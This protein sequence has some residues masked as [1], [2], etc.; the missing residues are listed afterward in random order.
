[1]RVAAAAVVAVV[2][3][4][5][6]ETA[7]AQTD[8]SR[9]MLSVNAA[10]EPGDEE[11]TDTGTFTLY[12]EA[13]VL[14]VSG[15]SSTGAIFD[16]GAAV[17]VTGQFTLGLSYH[18]GASADEQTA[19]G[20]A[21]HPVVFNRPRPFSVTVPEAKRIEQ[22]VHISAGYLVPLGEKFDL[23]IYGGPTQFRYSQQVIGSVTITE[24]S[25]AF[26]AVNATPT[27]V[28]RKENIWGGHIGADMSYPIATSGVTSFRLGGYIR[29]A[30]A[31]SEF[32]VVS[33][34]VETETGGVQYG[35]GL[36]VRF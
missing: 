11:F 36:R 22:A 14:T 17:R 28:A 15:R 21:P 7:F 20:L 12:D 30:Q 9:F 18:R 27:V 16:F 29:Y 24:A 33:N 35:A 26:T 1:M 3:F 32:L 2:V 19:S 4:C 31:S 25:G 10:Y 6:A 13:G 8:E 34:N 5:G 23:H